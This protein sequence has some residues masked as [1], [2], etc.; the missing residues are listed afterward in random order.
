[1]YANIFDHLMRH[2]TGS[3][4]RR[5]AVQALAAGGLS[6]LGLQGWLGAAD[7]R[8]DRCRRGKIRT[9][10]GPPKQVEITFQAHRGLV[11][12]LVTESDNADTVVP[13]FQVGT[14][15]PVVVTATKIDRSQPARV[16]I[17][18]T[19]SRQVARTCTKTF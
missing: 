5:A 16:T 14:T 6:A 7:A 18:T 12:I 9:T 10:A 1:M 8:R 13:P 11:E 19:N 17:R 15:D 3:R 4:S 2:L